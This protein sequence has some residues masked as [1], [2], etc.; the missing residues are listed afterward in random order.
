MDPRVL[1]PLEEVY[2]G[3][4]CNS[5]LKKCAGSR[6]SYSLS[7][8]QT[9]A[10][11]VKKR[12]PVFGP[13]CHEI[14]F[15][16]PKTALST[17]AGGKLPA[18]PTLQNRYAHL[19]PDASR[20]EEEWR[21]LPSYFSKDE[22]LSLEVKPPALFRANLHQ[23]RTFGDRQVFLNIVTLAQLILS[24]PHSNA[25]TEGI[26]SHMA[27]VKTKKRNRLGKE[28][29]NSVLVLKSAFAASGC[30]CANMTVEHGH[31]KIH[32]KQMY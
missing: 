1:L 5:A 10:V 22:K 17:E 25:A 21:M 23:M 13:L 30:T 27:G 2:L 9:A 19:L 24:L 26:F 28:N 12:L 14:Q 16:T 6:P 3:E 31:P 4:G 18:L 15:L 11:E 32:S 29:L 20:V 7:F 8:Y